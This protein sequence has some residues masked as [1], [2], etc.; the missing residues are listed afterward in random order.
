MWKYPLD[1]NILKETTDQLSKY[2]KTAGVIFLILGAIGIIYPTVMTVITVTFISWLMLFAGLM[3]GYFT[4][5]SDKDDHIGW[6]KSFVLIGVS[7]FMILYPMS[8]IG[9]IG[10]LLS[11]YFFMDAFASFSMGLNMKQSKG[12]IMWFVNAFFSILL[13]ILFIVGWPLSSVYL[14]GLLVGFSLFFD[15]ISLLTVGSI[16]KKLE[17]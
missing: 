6:L 17:K 2:A 13:G 14:I 7:L 15:G 5:L 16:F 3:A 4:Y 10:L 8:G 9:T 12:G 1:K 11:I